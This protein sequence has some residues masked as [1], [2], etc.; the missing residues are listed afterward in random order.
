[1]DRLS[2]QMFG[3]AAE[4]W[5]IILLCLVDAA[6]GWRVYAK[7]GKPGWAVL[8]PIYNVVVLLRIA[9]CPPWW[10]FLM[11][12]PLVSQIV[13]ILIM[14]GLA[15]KFGKGIGFGLALG[16]LG[17]IFLPILGFGSSKYQSSSV[18]C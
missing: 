1:M 6:G 12:I 2:P 15:K 5:A 8:I 4:E 11:F 13:F 7:A 17:P 18:I 16:L 3:I 10:I 14:I 9:G